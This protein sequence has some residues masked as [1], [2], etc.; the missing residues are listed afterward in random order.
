MLSAMRHAALFIALIAA[1]PMAPQPVMAA[2]LP[3]IT[4]KDGVI[5]PARINVPAG[6]TVRIVVRNTGRA[7]AEFESKALHI[8]RIVPPAGQIVITLRNPAPGAYAFV[9]EFTENRASSHGVIIA[10]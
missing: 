6:K 2:G 7:A 10:K 5:T 1:A 4:M 8:E 9:D 3:V